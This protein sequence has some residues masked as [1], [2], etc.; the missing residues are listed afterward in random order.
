MILKIAV[1]KS[2]V[3]GGTALAGGG[4]IAARSGYKA[5]LKKGLLTGR[6]IA[7]HGTTEANRRKILQEGIKG[8]FTAKENTTTNKLAPESAKS[9]RGVSFLTRNRSDAVVYGQKAEMFQNQGA[10]SLADLNE[11]IMKDPKL[12]KKITNMDSVVQ[13]N[14]PTWKH[15]VVSNPELR[16]LSK[17]DWIKDRIKAEE[18]LKKRKLSYIERPLFEREYSKVHRGLSEGTIPIKGD[19][20]PR[21][22]KGSK[23]YKPN[24]LREVS[25][26]IRKKPGRFLRGVSKPA[27]GLAAIGAGA[28]LA[29]RG[30]KKEASL[31]KTALNALKGGL[32]QV[33][34]GRR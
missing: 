19:V 31:N 2:K 15:K 3:I 29:Y 10:Q 1:E 24:S 28:M 22:I 30:V 4:T 11:K 32:G 14:I 25:R 6:E 7:F 8:K 21:Y 27:I 20:S 9:S 33:G 16:G 13:A 23:H 17:Q 5:S 34:R 26:F 12:A 18:V